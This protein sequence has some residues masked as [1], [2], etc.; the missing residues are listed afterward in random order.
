[1]IPPTLLD[2]LD[3]LSRDARLALRALRR[4]AAA[5]RFATAIVALGIGASAMVFSI[6]NALL[7]RGGASM[8]VI[9]PR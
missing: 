6:C 5:W 4:D 3:V 1:M 8:G 2:F 7:L 9:R